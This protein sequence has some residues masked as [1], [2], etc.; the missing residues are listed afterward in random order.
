[1]FSSA[2]ASAHHKLP[3]PFDEIVSFILLENVVDADYYLVITCVLLLILAF[4]QLRAFARPPP[5]PLK[6]LPQRPAIQLLFKPDDDL[7]SSPAKENAQ[8]TTLS[9]G[10]D[11]T[12][13]SSASSFLVY[14]I[15]FRIFLWSIGSFSRQWPNG[16]NDGCFVVGRRGKV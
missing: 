15:D 2:I 3:A 11:T 9:A 12:N 10:S 16:Y 7:A 4:V 8:Q 1:M 5:V 6:K 13:E 14:A